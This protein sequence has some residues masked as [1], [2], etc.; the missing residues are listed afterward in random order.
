MDC[1][2]LV[3]GFLGC[4]KISNAVARGF[5]GAPGSQRPRK[6]IVSP[7]NAEKAAALKA[8]FPDMVEIGS[9]NE[10]VVEGSNIVFIGLVPEV[11]RA[12]LPEM[13]FTSDHHLISM[14]AAVNYDEVVSLTR[15]DPS[16]LIKTVPLPGAARRTG[17]ILSFPPNTYSE[18]VLSIVGT[19]VPCTA[20]KDMKPLISITGHISP[21]FELMNVTQKWVVEQGLSPESARLYISAFYSGLASSAAMSSESFADMVEEAATPGGLNE[22]TTAFL[23]GTEHYNLHTQSLDTVLNR[24]KG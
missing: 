20:E 22:Q 2:D 12:V 4:G 19:P 11:A 7:R 9:T 16:R 6:I 5:I 8:E 10:A 18:A 15:V 13:P 14:M 3:I 23:R 21:F 17:P 1:S 24:L